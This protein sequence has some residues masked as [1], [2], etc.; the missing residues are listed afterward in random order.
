M[1]KYIILFSVIALLFLVYLLSGVLKVYR[2]KD[3]AD[4]ETVQAYIK[5][6]KIIMK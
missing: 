1:I 5:K 2:S 3:D 6:Q 4:V